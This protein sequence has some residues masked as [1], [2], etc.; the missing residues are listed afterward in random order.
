MKEA[1]LRVL[2]SYTEREPVRTAKAYGK[3]IR[4][5]LAASSSRIIN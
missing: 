3:K 1:D 2:D 4:S 5:N